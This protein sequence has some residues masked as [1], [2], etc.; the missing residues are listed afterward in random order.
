MG[1]ADTTFAAVDVGTTKVCAIV[2]RRSGPNRVQVL[3]H[4]TVP[5]DGL[6]KGDVSDADATAQA[7]RRAVTEASQKSG[8]SIDAAYV[9]VTGAHVSFENRWDA[10]DWVGGQGVIT[11]EDLKLVP[12]RVSSAAATDGRRIIHAI[13]LTYGMDGEKTIRNPLGMH[14]RNLEVET[15]VVSGGQRYL[16]RLV[17]AVE[18][19]GIRVKDLVFEPLAS[20]EA[21]LT[22][23]EK[24]AGVALIDIG[25]GTTD[26]IVY[27]GGLV[28]YTGVVPVGGFQ[29]T[30]DI[31]QTYGTS[32]EDAE[33]AKL[34]HATIDLHKSKLI[35]EI[36]LPVE[37]CDVELKVP[38]RE[39][40]QLTR[41]R[42]QEL[43]RLVKVKLQE[44]DIEDI[45]K[46]DLVFTG[47]ASNLP[48]LESLTRQILTTHVRI[49]MPNGNGSI[50]DELK[51][52]A[53]SA[54]VGLLLWAAGQSVQEEAELAA[55]NGYATNG[56]AINGDSKNG[57]STS[58]W[59][60]LRFMSRLKSRLS[61]NLF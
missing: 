19:A 54:G 24:R 7:I 51:A 56:H 49:G 25:G 52:P 33:Q 43:L 26:I 12:E 9:G 16:R 47:G 38:H 17:E 11:N 1:Q 34:E 4:S 29:F 20:G 22:E 53:Y 6:R 59:S 23:E 50:P 28:R 18:S 21:V 42:A 15:H 58:G 40:C 48:G 14:A 13:P 55:T 27:K 61:L 35:E 39:F 10:L 45:S 2:G 3:A 31:C 32:F 46:L 8:V 41:E 57:A 30:N 5:C 37:D 36:T 44:S 60:A